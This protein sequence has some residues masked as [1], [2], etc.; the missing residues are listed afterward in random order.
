MKFALIPIAACV[1]AALL[2]GV[3]LFT[4]SQA[5]KWMIIVAPL[6]VPLVW[7]LKKSHQ[8]KHLLLTAFI[9][10]LGFS[11]DIPILDVGRG[12]AWMRLGVV[13]LSDITL[14]ALVIFA[15]VTPPEKRKNRPVFT[16]DAR[17]VFGAF[18]A[19][20]A[21]LLG[22]L[23]FS[24]APLI[25]ALS[26]LQLIRGLLIIWVLCQTID[27]L[28]TLKVALNALIFI[29]L[30]N[31]AWALL[32]QVNQGSLGLTHLG[33]RARG[34]HEF[35]AFLING[36]PFRSY[37]SGFIGMPYRL[38]A[39][40]MLCLPVI[41]A[42][43]LT[44][45]VPQRLFVTAAFVCSLSAVFLCYSRA[46][47]SCTAMGLSVVVLVL[48]LKRRLNP[49]YAIVGLVIVAGFGLTHV[50]MLLG[51]FLESNLESSWQN[52][53]GFFDQAWTILKDT[54]FIGTGFGASGASTSKTIHSLYF[55]G[56]AESGPVGMGLF[57]L[58][59]LCVIKLGLK[60]L[61]APHPFFETI[62]MG[63]LLGILAIFL[64]GVVTWMFWRTE[65]NSMAFTLVGLLS[66][67][68]GLGEENR[69]PENGTPEVPIPSPAPSL[70]LNRRF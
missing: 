41:W 1:A 70:A 67:L 32:Q 4:R 25:T 54:G 46:I 14:T 6:A 45:A 37:I 57:L 16:P 63:L 21:W 53:L 36:K 10:S 59:Q 22:T 12:S 27:S 49:I 13:Y 34:M 64:Q 51:R 18:G 56:L 61:S 17:H 24:D 33:E 2:E 52:R 5:L 9:I 7:G 3:L 62:A 8:K 60:Q 58:F 40:L 47:W 39:F 65:L 38:G 29:A 11:A 42:A 66:A 68:A 35:Q 55:L 26:T 28:K 23:I 31:G 20:S 44:R 43:L 19:Y 50:D 69:A 15:L 48:T 30:L